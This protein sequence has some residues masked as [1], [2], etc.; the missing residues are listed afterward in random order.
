MGI[1]L[2]I[3]PARGGSKGI[4]RK[5]I[6]ELAGKPLLAW[7]IEAALDVAAIDKLVVSTDDSE[8]E[9]VAKAFGA[10]VFRR[11][12]EAAQDHVHSV[13]AA[14]ECLRFYMNRGIIVDRVVM[15]N[16]TAPLKTAGDIEGAI[17]QL[18]STCDS[19]IG[20]SCY[21]K[22][23]SSLRKMVGDIMLP[24][25]KV[26]KFET[27]RQEIK[28]KLLEVNGSIYVSTPK[29]LFAAESFHQGNIKPFIMS[30]LHSIDIN[31]LEDFELAEAL[32]CQK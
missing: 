26:K 12:P 24:V 18:D 19:V 21:D 22:P 16:C 3:I 20:V 5:N 10:E 8:I 4:P 23:V 32:L 9:E 31:N 2:A 13:H 27:Q 29:H 6:K 7:T 1:N 11:G 25:I 15:L 17:E 28:E 14:L 30:K